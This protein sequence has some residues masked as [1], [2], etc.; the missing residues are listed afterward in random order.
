MTRPGPVVIAMVDRRRSARSSRASW[1][2]AR[3]RRRAAL[4]IGVE[5]DHDAG[6]SAAR[7]L[8]ARDRDAAWTLASCALARRRRRAARS[9]PASR[10][11]VLGGYA[12]QWP[13]HYL[14][15]LLGLALI[16]EA[17]ARVRDEELAAHADRAAR[18]RRSPTPRGRATSPRSRPALERTLADV[19]TLTTRGEGRTSRRRV[20][21]GDADGLPVRARIERIDGSVIALDVVRRPRD[22]RGPRRDADRCGRS[23]TRALGANPSGPP[24]A[25]PFKIGRRRV[26]RPLPACA[27]ARSRSSKLFDDAAARARGDARSTAGSRTGSATACAIACIPAAARRSIIRCR[28][29]T[30]R[31]AAPASAGAARRGDRAARRDRARAASTRRRARRRAARRSSASIAKGTS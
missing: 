12:F 16:A 7:D 3:S 6:R 14:L 30:S 9:A 8:P 24:A 15:P 4:A 1:Y 17:R 29:R 20:I 25:P 13:N 10:S 2:P 23:P 21:V 31:S 11:I 26:R 5:L 18:R 19:H 28:C 22:R 27:A